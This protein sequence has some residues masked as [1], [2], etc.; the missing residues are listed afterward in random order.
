LAELQN[1]QF[2]TATKADADIHAGG[3]FFWKTYYDKLTFKDNGQVELARVSLKDNGFD[4]MDEV[5]MSTGIYK[6]PTVGYYDVEI[7]LTHV[8]QKI[9][10]RYCGKVVETGTLICYGYIKLPIADSVQHETEIYTE[11]NA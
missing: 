6:K 11:I 5:L 2:R 3:N 4:R 7:E 10:T 1:R 8:S 9:L